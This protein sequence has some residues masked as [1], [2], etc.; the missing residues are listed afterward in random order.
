MKVHLLI[1]QKF[2]LFNNE[3]DKAKS[4]LTIE[5]SSKPKLER[6]PSLLKGRRP[7]RAK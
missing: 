2:L 4:T 5:Y 1:K 3:A 7:F 6:L